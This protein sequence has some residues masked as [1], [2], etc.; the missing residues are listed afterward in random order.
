MVVCWF[1]SNCS[2]A[3]IGAG[4]TRY[5]LRGPVRFD[6]LRCVAAF[7]VCAGFLGPFLSSF[8]DAG[9]VALNGWGPR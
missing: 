8:I 5:L 4:L 6:N 1:I 9:F 2:E 3:V 7:C